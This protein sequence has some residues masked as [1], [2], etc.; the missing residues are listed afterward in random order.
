MPQPPTWLIPRFYFPSL[1]GHDR[2]RVQTFT[3]QHQFVRERP[4]PIGCRKVHFVTY[5]RQGALR[6]R[7][8]GRIVVKPGRS[9]DNLCQNTSRGGF[10]NAS[11]AVTNMMFRLVV[12]AWDLVERGG[13]SAE[14]PMDAGS[15]RTAAEPYT[16]LNPTGS[17]ALPRWQTNSLS[18]SRRP[19]WKRPSLLPQS[20]TQIFLSG[21]T[22][23]P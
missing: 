2:A 7:Y 12:P 8:L 16:N 17:P 15:M 19:K 13:L 18:R 11:V 23:C 22:D 10:R 21:L 1:T 3:S 4:L 14:T 20:Y 6:N 5:G 9:N